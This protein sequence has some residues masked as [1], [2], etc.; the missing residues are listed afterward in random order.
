MKLEGFVNGAY[1]LDSVNVDAQRCVNLYPEAIESGTGKGGNQGYLKNTP[2]LEAITTVGNGPIRMIHRDANNRIFIASG[3]ELYRYA[4]DDDQETILWADKFINGGVD[5]G[6][7]GTDS[8]NI[9]ISTDNFHKSSGI[10]LD[11]WYTGAKVKFTVTSGTAPSGIIEDEEYYLIYVATQDFKL[12]TTLENAYNGV[13][14]DITNAGA[15]VYKFLQVTGEIRINLKKGDI[16]FG[17]NT[18]SYPDGHNLISGDRV[19]LGSHGCDLPTGL[20]HFFDGI[21]V[22]TLYFVIK[23]SANSFRLATSIANVV[24]DTDVSFS[25]PGTLVSKVSKSSFIK[26]DKILLSIY[27]TEVNFGTS[28]GRVTASSSRPGATEYSV[29]GLMCDG[30]TP[31]QFDGTTNNPFLKDATQFFSSEPG[32]W[33]RVDGEQYHSTSTVIDIAFSEASHIDW[34]DGYFILSKK[35]TP[36]FY[37]SALNDLTVDALSFA[38]AEGSPDLIMSIISNVRDLW[39]FGERTTEVYVNTGNPDFPFERI[40]SGFIEIGCAAANSVNKI[41]GVVF[42]LG[43]SSDGEGVVYMASGMQPQ[44]ISTHPIEQAISSYADISTATSYTYQSNG[45]KFYVLNFDE[46]T[47]VF[48]MS[49]GTWHERAYTNSGVLERHRGDTNCYDQN[50]QDHL[51]GD[52]STNNLYKF[53]DTIYEDN[54]NTITRLRTLPHYSNE[55]YQMFWDELWLDMQTGVGLASGQG[56]DPQ[57]MLD[58]SDDGG[59]T[60]SDESWTSAGGQSGGIGEY[61]TRVRWRRLGRARDRILRFKITDPVKTILI[62]AYVKVRQGFN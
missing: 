36:F 44:K 8:G 1:T 33:V 29:L 55:N 13:A 50:A 4:A 28:T 54:G 60:W 12:A 14:I 58:W 34:I 48:D 42:W 2:G 26:N 24:S 27:P 10:S 31:I 6:W 15:G 52:Y 5:S 3:D 19:F 45:H 21:S 57:V 62:A 61:A 22:F 35:L 11:Y 49:T 43:R 59:H 56:S 37:T 32:F 51:V 38:Q 41:E 16:D 20:T 53:S 7:I 47:W 18:F 9:T 46:A 40:Q 39:V 23:D 17:T 30:N 25:D